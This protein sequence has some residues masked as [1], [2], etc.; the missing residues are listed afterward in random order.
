MHGQHIYFQKKAKEF[1]AVRSASR[2]RPQFTSAQSAVGAQCHRS[3]TEIPAHRYGCFSTLVQ[4]YQR[5]GTFLVLNSAAPEY[6]V[7]IPRTCIFC[8]DASTDVPKLAAKRTPLGRKISRR[9]KRCYDF[10][11]PFGN[12]NERFSNFHFVFR[13]L[14]RNSGCAEVTHVRK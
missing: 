1:T 7:F 14:N 10:A 8:R 5:S 13:S 2:C 11:P 4:L 12:K 9:R 3:G 6:M